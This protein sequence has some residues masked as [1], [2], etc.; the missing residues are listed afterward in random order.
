MPLL[1][2]VGGT[3]E[4]GGKLMFDMFKKRKKEIIEDTPCR[5]SICDVIAEVN[6]SAKSGEFYYGTDAC[7]GDPFVLNRKVH[8]PRRLLIGSPGSGKTWSMFSE[9]KQVSENTSDDI[10]MFYDWNDDNA[11]LSDIKKICID[12]VYPG[13]ND[14]YYINPLDVV[15]TSYDLNE[16]IDCSYM[17]PQLCEVA[18]AFY[19]SI[20]GVVTVPEIALLERAVKIV[21][22]PF[23]KDLIERKL[24]HDFENNPTFSDIIRAVKKDTL[25]PDAIKLF[26]DV[27]EIFEDRY[28][29]LISS[30]T[31]IE[32]E[33]RLII[34]N[35][36]G[37]IF[38]DIAM[39]SFLSFAFNRMVLNTEKHRSTWV[40]IDEG[41]KFIRREYISELFFSVM[42]RS[43]K[44]WGLF[45][46]SFWDAEEGD[47]LF[48]KV[49]NLSDFVQCFTTCIS[50]LFL[51]KDRL[52]L[53][54]ESIDWVYGAPYGQCLNIV[55][56]NV[57]KVEYNN[58]ILK[59]THQ[60]YK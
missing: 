44:F 32:N 6:S 15:L 26:S 5:K 42:K 9:V 18:V 7:T 12:S 2:K 55:C 25:Y 38:E 11:P 16:G 8:A 37:K 10:L 54:E 4:I 23:V 45:T 24:T 49:L 43:R 30:K 21:F 3:L 47:P 46:V 14:R 60:N 34:C 19:E 1:A 48:F 33:E 53:N 58:S 36:N 28:P 17:L 59:L 52:M 35:K 29:E 31:N 56:G 27:V 57:S 50:D 51:I 22:E 40:Y 20:K 41:H 13:S 39:V